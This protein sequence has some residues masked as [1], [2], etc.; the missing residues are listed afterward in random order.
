MMS[1][2]NSTIFE[3][4]LSNAVQF[5]RRHKSSAN[6]RRA[7]QKVVDRRPRST[8]TSPT[9]AGE[10]IIII[11]FSSATEISIQKNLTNLLLKCSKNERGRR[12]GTTRA[13]SIET[14]NH[15]LVSA[16]LFIFSRN[17][18]KRFR[19]DFR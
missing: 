19:F 1:L 14:V 15:T 4:C 5:F 2:L 9:M 7:E 10:T 3:G 12:T 13:I 8:A 16:T 6:D 17:A 18:P 11:F